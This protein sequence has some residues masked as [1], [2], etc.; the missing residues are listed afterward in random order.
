LPN[1]YELR[2]VDVATGAMTPL[3][4]AR[5]TAPLQVI[6]FSPEGDRILFSRT[7]ATNATS[8]WSVRVDGSGAQLL[9]TGVGWA[10]WQWQPA[11]R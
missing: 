5:G 3:A 10:D 7:D 2:V 4:S 9:V 6:N 8:V 11:D 1:D